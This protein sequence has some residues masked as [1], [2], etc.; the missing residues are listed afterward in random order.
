MK[1][2]EKTD[3]EL[4][5]ENAKVILSSVQQ[6]KNRKQFQAINA[7]AQTLVRELN[8]LTIDEITGEV[9]EN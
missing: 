3:A 6:Y 1:D 9:V 4:L 8:S 7:A 2:R 5:H